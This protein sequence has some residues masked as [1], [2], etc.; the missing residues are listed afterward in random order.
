MSTPIITHSAP[1]IQKM[2]L[3]ATKHR[4]TNAFLTIPL[5]KHFYHVDFQHWLNLVSKMHDLA[6]SILENDSNFKM[7]IVGV[8]NIQYKET[9][10]KIV[11]FLW[12]ATA[13][14][15]QQFK[16]HLD[17]FINNEQIQSLQAQV[18]QLKCFPFTFSQGK[19]EQV[20]L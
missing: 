9:I 5:P 17:R 14:S 16:Q 10:G 2:E 8:G 3:Q 20:N 11:V 15:R 12:F 4:C 6:P 13:L 19:Q 1:Y 18:N 7:I